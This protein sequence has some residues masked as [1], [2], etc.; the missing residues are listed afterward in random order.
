MTVK[1]F[2]DSFDILVNSFPISGNYAIPS[3]AEFDE[4]E[5]SVLLTAA[6]ED[7]I[8]ELYSGNTG[9]RSFEETEELRRCLDG[10][11]KTDKPS[12][13]DSE[14]DLDRNSTFFHLKDDVWFITYESVD[15]EEGAYCPSNPTVRVVPMRQDEW[16]RAKENPFRRPSRRKVVRLDSG[17]NIVELVSE[18]P[19]T[20]YLIRYLR[21]PSPIILTT[22]EDDMSINGRKEV[23]ECELNTVLHRPILERAVQLAS[24]RAPRAEN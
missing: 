11:I 7:L 10:L 16:H 13:I 12:R 19:I 4:Y 6:Q 18:Y 23:T 24:R 9:R 21:R 5:K 2:S 22:L 1:E 14:D 8:R 3:P 17:N 20:N 15:L